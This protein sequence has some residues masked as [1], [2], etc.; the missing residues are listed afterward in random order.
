M[1]S[2]RRCKSNSGFSNFELKNFNVIVMNVEILLFTSVISKY[3][4]VKFRMLTR[5]INRREMNLLKCDLNYVA[6]G[7][8]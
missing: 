6:A 1:D 8:M 4:K 2:N 3:C 7:K 5:D